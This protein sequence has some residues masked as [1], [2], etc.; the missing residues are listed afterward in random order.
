MTSFNTVKQTTVNVS[1]TKMSQQK[2]TEM[3]QEKKNSV[4][5]SNYSNVNASVSV[6]V[7]NSCRTRQRMRPGHTL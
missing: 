5:Y 4:Y 1:V 6:I 2:M 3:F 7:L